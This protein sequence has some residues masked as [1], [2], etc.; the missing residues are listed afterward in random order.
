MGV[1]KLEFALECEIK[2]YFSLNQRCSHREG[3]KNAFTAGNRSKHVIMESLT[4]PMLIDFEYSGVKII[5]L[6]QFFATA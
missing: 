3:P 4:I 6:A 5:R 2:L 1:K